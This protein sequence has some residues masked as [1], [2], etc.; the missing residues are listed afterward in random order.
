MRGI[1]RVKRG[2]IVFD[3]R[4]TVRCGDQCCDHTSGDQAECPPYQRF[5]RHQP[6]NSHFFFYLLSALLCSTQVSYT[7]NQGCFLLNSDV[8]SSPCFYLPRY[9][10]ASQ[11]CFCW[12]FHW[13]IVSGGDLAPSPSWHHTSVHRSSHDTSLS[14]QQYCH[15]PQLHWL[16]SLVHPYISNIRSGKWSNLKI[17]IKTRNSVDG[18]YFHPLTIDNIIYW[19]EVYDK[20][21]KIIWKCQN[22]ADI[23]DWFKVC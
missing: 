20:W 12:V 10:C 3:D 6:C 4:W 13:D 11:C 18:F 8:L 21:K 15:M 7:S 19:K 2:E 22:Y 1:W 23:Q 16:T 17:Y 14:T 9:D 5:I